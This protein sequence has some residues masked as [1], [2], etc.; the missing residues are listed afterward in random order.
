MNS[1]VEDVGDSVEPDN[2][3]SDD[4]NTIVSRITQGLGLGQLCLTKRKYCKK[5]NEIIT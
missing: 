5:S 3:L 2:V 1:A 4:W